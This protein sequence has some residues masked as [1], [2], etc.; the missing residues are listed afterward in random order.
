M[1]TLLPHALH[2]LPSWSLAVG[3]FLLGSAHGCVISEER[4]CAGCHHDCGSLR[5]GCHQECDAAPV[6]KTDAGELTGVTSAQGDA[7]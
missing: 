4:S 2:S 5:A 7:S 3:L 6:C 1:I